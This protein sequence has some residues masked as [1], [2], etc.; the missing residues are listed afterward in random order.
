MGLLNGV[1]LTIK[2]IPVVKR[3]QDMGVLSLPAGPS[4]VRFL[5]PFP[6][7]ENDFRKAADVLAEALKEFEG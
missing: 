3:M 7:E 4:V 6:A 2:A 5:P 1:E